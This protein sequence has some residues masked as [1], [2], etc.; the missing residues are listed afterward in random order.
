M[1]AC[2][3][4]N[5]PC[6][7]HF[8]EWNGNTHCCRRRRVISHRL[9]APC[10]FGKVCCL[11]SLKTLDNTHQYHWEGSCIFESLWVSKYIDRKSNFFIQTATAVASLT[12]VEVVPSRVISTL[13]HQKSLCIYH[14]LRRPSCIYLTR[15]SV[16]KMSHSWV[17]LSIQARFVDRFL[18][19]ATQI[20]IVAGLFLTV[21]WNPIWS[22]VNGQCLT[23]MPLRSI[24]SIHVH[25]FP[26]R[27]SESSRVSRIGEH[28]IEPCYADSN[29]YHFVSNG[30]LKALLESS[31][32]ST[33]SSEESLFI[34]G[35]L[36]RC[37]AQNIR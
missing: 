11:P 2:L 26:T 35:S 31:E 24:S 8:L 7:G 22:Q 34:E 32:R 23:L 10:A 6:T 3:T 4:Q 18:S 15:M 36:L 12:A 30:E 13:W 27:I 37:R 17:F 16:I 20:T 33:F 21:S 1:R 29:R 28:I 5:I 19:A 9:A 25:W 14:A